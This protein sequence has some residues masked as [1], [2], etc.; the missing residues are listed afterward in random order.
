MKAG[1]TH[2]QGSDPWVKAGGSH[3]ALHFAAKCGSTD[4]ALALLDFVEAHETLNHPR[5]SCR[6]D[7]VAGSHC[8]RVWL[9]VC[10][11]WKSHNVHTCLHTCFMHAC[12]CVSPNPNVCL[13]KRACTWACP[14]CVPM[15]VCMQKY[16]SLN[17]LPH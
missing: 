6:S 15:Y 12:V 2:T 3:A 9:R 14:E 17:G 7:R 16:D 8:M 1:G 10:V 5:D 4:C 13:F 11:L